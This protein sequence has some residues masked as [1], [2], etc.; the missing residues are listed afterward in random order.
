MKYLLED[1]IVRT[2]HGVTCGQ[3]Y[4]SSLC[5]QFH[6]KQIWG[7]GALPTCPS[8]NI[9]LTIAV[10]R[11][12]YFVPLRIVWILNTFH[13]LKLASYCF[14]NGLFQFGEHFCVTAPRQP[15]CLLTQTRLSSFLLSQD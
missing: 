9:A 1:A 15:S 5:L 13:K 2:V 7:D 4:C 10:A 8:Q 3:P 14:V 6:Q 11:S 12:I